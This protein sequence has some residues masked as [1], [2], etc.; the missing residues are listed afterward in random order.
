[1]NGVV[2]H[3]KREILELPSVSIICEDEYLRN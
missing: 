2:A 1:M 3:V